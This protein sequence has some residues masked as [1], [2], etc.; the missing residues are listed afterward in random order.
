M[1]VIED[2]ELREYQSSDGEFFDDAQYENYKFEMWHNKQG[3]EEEMWKAYREY[4]IQA[5][6]DH[7]GQNHKVYLASS[8]A[9]KQIGLI[10]IAKRDPFWKYTDPLCW[11]YNLY[12]RSEYRKL[13]IGKKLMMQAEKWAHDQCLHKIALHVADF[14]YP[15]IK[16]YQK[17]GYQMTDTHNWSCFYE[18]NI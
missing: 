13:G 2:I 10:W 5:P 12:V 1:L 11:I 17:L 4:L 14:N 15:A 3:T 7:T 6:L 9:E 16:F 18:K 8:S